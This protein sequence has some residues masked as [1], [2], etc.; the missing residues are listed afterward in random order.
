MFN[1]S[2][3]PNNFHFIATNF[4]LKMSRFLA[5]QGNSFITEISHNDQWKERNLFCKTVLGFFEIGLR[6]RDWHLFIGGL[7]KFKQFF[8]RSTLMVIF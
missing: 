2:D 8:L 3:P 4:T 7:L 1:Q 6:L 5:F